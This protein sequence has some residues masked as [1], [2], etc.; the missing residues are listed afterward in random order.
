MIREVSEAE[1]EKALSD[2][3]REGFA[4]IEGVA[5]PETLG[6]LRSRI[7]AL[8][9][10]THPDPGLFFQPD[11]TTG[12]YEDVVN[13]DGWRGPDVAYRKIDRLQRDE[14]FLGW[15][16]NP[17]FARLCSEV[18]P[19]GTSLYRTVLFSKAPN[20]GTPIPWHQDAG[21][22]W[23]LDRNPELQAWTALDDA[24]VEA[25]CLWVIPRSHRWG[26]ATEMGGLVPVAEVEKRQVNEGI[27]VPVSAGDVVLVHSLVWHRSGS[28]TTDRPR[29]GLTASFLDADTQCVRKKRAPRNFLR[30]FP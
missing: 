12:R 6:T 7:E 16:R 10:G 26:L 8:I 13:E 1:V 18:Y 11:A 14:L 4:K 22:L 25:G 27:A 19:N 23:G 29:R 21:K 15:V 3:R 20:L 9:A 28:N 17:L 5:T 24:S 2:W 30:V